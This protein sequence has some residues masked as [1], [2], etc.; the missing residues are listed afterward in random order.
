MN[1]NGFRSQAWSENAQPHSKARRVASPRR[2]RKFAG[3][4]SRYALEYPWNVWHLS[5]ASTHNFWGTDGFHMFSH[6]HFEATSTLDICASRARA[7]HC[8]AQSVPAPFQRQRAHLF[9]ARIQGLDSIWVNYYILQTW[10]KAILGWFPLLTMI[11]VRSQ[12]GRYNL[13]GFHEV[14]RGDMGW[15]LL[16]F[17]HFFKEIASYGFNQSQPLRWPLGA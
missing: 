9:L 14:F 5:K 10:N 7:R 8:D 1:V 16:R 13:P 17:G 15:P 11:P 6:L 4:V 2:G 12:W 3:K